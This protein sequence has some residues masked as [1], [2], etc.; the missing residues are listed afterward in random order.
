[1]VPA[2]VLPGHHCVIELSRCQNRNPLVDLSIDLRLFRQLQSAGSTK[3]LSRH[4]RPVD[5]L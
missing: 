4:T 1:M 2:A 5:T 3:R